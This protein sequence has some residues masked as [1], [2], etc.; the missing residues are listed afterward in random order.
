MRRGETP[1][2]AANE[3]VV[4]FLVHLSRVVL[5]CHDLA[6]AGVKGRTI[7]YTESVGG[8]LQ[9]PDVGDIAP[10]NGSKLLS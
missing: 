10:S 6:L 2:D 8:G 3:I 1:L 9:F 4:E 5:L 7:A